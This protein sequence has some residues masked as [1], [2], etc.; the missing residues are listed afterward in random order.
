VVRRL[1]RFASRMT[2]EFQRQPGLQHLPDHPAQ[3]APGAGQ[4]DRL[5]GLRP[6]HQLRGQIRDHLVRQHSRSG[7]PA[8]AGCAT[9]SPEIGRPRSLN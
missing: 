4:L 7:E 1:R 9:T 6:G 8:A 5:P 2:T 3:Q